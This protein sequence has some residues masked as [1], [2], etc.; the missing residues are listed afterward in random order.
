MKFILTSIPLNI[1]IIMNPF[2][3]HYESLMGTYS[4]DK[5]REFSSGF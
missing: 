5:N 4:S 1:V 2:E 3:K